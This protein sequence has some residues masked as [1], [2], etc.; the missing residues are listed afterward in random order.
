MKF[1][2]KSAFIEKTLAW[3]DF[4]KKAGEP[5]VVAID[6]RDYIQK[7]FLTQEA[8]E[9][10]PD[11]A[12]KQLAEFRS[13]NKT[14]LNELGK[15]KVRTASFDLLQKVILK[16]KKYRSQTLLI[17][18]QVGKQVR[19]LMY[20]LELAGIKNYYFLRGGANSVIGL[21]AYGKN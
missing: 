4:K 16:N 1:I 11:S 14:M 3:E 6:T 19:W 17:F 9:R 12:R 10:L 20:N 5:G 8:E 13:K 15:R 18:D 21:Q 2:P 7:G